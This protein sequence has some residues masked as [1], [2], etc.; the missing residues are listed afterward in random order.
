MGHFHID[1]D[2]Y[3]QQCRNPACNTSF[4]LHQDRD[5]FF[6]R[7]YHQSVSALRQPAFWIGVTF[8]FP[9]EHALWLKVWPFKLVTSLMGLS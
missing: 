2:D 7:C 3:P 1:D 4:H 9:L 6:H 5:G 8:S